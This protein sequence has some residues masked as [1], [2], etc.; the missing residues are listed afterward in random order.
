MVVAAFWRAWQPVAGARV[1]GGVPPP[2]GNAPPHPP[3]ALAAGRALAAALVLVEIGNTGDRPDQV[4]RFVHHYDGG[5]AEAPAQL[6][7][8]VKIHRRID[9]Q[10]APPHTT[11]PTPPHTHLTLTP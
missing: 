1:A 6:A 9:D 8:A 4:G 7:E 3:R 11:P 10:L 2:A 5:G